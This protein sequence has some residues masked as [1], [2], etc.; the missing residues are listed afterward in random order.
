MTKT[1]SSGGQAC[2]CHSS[3]VILSH[4]RSKMLCFQIQ[5]CVVHLPCLCSP[6]NSPQ[7]HLLQEEG[8]EGDRGEGGGGPFYISSQ[9]AINENFL[10][11]KTNN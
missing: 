4:S 7:A 9:L 3:C 11:N 8:K 6:A 5:S 1:V 10:K 2:P